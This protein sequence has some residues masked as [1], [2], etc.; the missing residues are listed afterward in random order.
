MPTWR[1]TIDLADVFHDEDRSFPQR[2]D[3]IV[4]RIHASGWAHDNT[5]VAA[6]LDEL[7]DAQTE[8]EFND[9]WDLIYDEADFDRVWLATF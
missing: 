5:D 9:A 6:L 8:E 4:S 1:T 7:A 2:R 3:E